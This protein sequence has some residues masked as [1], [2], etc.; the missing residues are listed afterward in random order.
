MVKQTSEFLNVDMYRSVLNVLVLQDSKRRLTMAE[1]TVRAILFIGIYVPLYV[2]NLVIT[3]ADIRFW[4]LTAF[5]IIVGVWRFMRWLRKDD[6]MN[7][8]RQQEI[9]TKR[10]ENRMKE[11]EMRE[12]EIEVEERELKLLKKG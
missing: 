12:R 8:M 6:R 5:S 3:F 11:L 10:L 9:E 4:V 2:Y 1:L 7:E